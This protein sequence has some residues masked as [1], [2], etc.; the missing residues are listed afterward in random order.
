MAKIS[1]GISATVKVLTFGPTILVIPGA[2]FINF[3]LPHLSVK[4]DCLAG[5]D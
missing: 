3:N 4:L 2:S 5:D 1:G